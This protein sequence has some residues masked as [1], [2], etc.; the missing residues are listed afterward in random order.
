MQALFTIGD[1]RRRLGVPLHRLQYA[2]DTHG[3][4][5]AKRI[6]IQRVW[7]EDQLPAIEESLRR[8]ADRGKTA[9]T[10]Q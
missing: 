1:L 6:G 5:P 4:Q 3:P 8:T 10:A 7:T 2:V 9:G